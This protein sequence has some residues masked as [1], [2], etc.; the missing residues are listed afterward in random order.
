MGRSGSGSRTLP[1]EWANPEKAPGLVRSLLAPGIT[2]LGQL[3][4]DG[5]RLAQLPAPPRKDFETTWSTPRGRVAF[6]GTGAN[7]YEGEYLLVVDLGGDDTY[8]GAAS[9]SGGRLAA[10]VVF[11]L[12]G[13]DTYAYMDSSRCGPGGAVLGFAGVFDFAGND[14][15]RGGAWGGGFGCWGWAGFETQRGKT[16]TLLP[17]WAKGLGSWGWGSCSTSLDMTATN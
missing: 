13:S 9:V 6:G 17:T 12:T 16:P 7:T 5:F 3:E 1:G 10:S 2:A 15:Y 14:R 11:D 8:L 4:A